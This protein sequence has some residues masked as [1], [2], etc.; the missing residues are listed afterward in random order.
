M[1][2]GEYLGDGVY[3]MMEGDDVVLSLDRDAN[4]ETIVLEP[5]VVDALIDYLRKRSRIVNTKLL[6]FLRSP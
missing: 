5:E 6:N 2:D 1:D 3:V 4:R